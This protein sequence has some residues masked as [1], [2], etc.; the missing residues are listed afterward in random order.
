MASPCEKALHRATLSSSAIIDAG[1]F[2]P[3]FAGRPDE[4]RFWRAVI[5]FDAPN[6]DI[7]LVAPRHRFPFFAG[8]SNRPVVRVFAN[9]TS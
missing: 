9:F 6:F 2:R 8:E 4:L 7:G 5:A 3:V 1:N